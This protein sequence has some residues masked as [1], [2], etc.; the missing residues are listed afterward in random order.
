MV[1][2]LLGTTTMGVCRPVLIAQWV[3]QAHPSIDGNGKTLLWFIRFIC[4]IGLGISLV[5]SL[6]I[7]RSFGI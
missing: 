6:V 3:K 7:I 1:L 5:F 2:F 4:A